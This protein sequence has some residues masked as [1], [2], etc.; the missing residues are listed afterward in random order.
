MIGSNEWLSVGWISSDAL[1]CAQ[2]ATKMNGI[3]TGSDRIMATVACFE[4]LGKGREAA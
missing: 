2:A 1:C 3:K 4:A